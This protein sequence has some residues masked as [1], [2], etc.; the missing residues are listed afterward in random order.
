VGIS[1]EGLAG[2]AEEMLPPLV[3]GL[4]PPY[5]DDK[6]STKRPKY[7]ATSPASYAAIH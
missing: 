4:P 1:D 7:G 3:K 5:G 6:L 2:E